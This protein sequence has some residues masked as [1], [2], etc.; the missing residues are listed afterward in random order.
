MHDHVCIIG[1][2]TI[3]GTRVPAEAIQIGEELLVSLKS[4]LTELVVNANATVLLR[5]ELEG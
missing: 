2:V 5:G 1:L 4:L 3:G